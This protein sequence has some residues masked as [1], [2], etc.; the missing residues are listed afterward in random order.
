MRTGLI[1][2]IT[3]T[4]SLS[5]FPNGRT[6]GPA[7]S[8]AGE[9]RAIRIDNKTELPEAGSSEYHGSSAFK[10]YTGRDPDYSLTYRDG[11]FPPDWTAWLEGDF[12][13][14]QD[15]GHDCTSETIDF[16]FNNREN[17]LEIGVPAEQNPGGA[18]FF[19]TGGRFQTGEEREIGRFFLRFNV[20]FNP[21]SVGTWQYYFYGMAPTPSSFYLAG[22]QKGY[23]ELGHPEFGVLASAEA[24]SFVPDQYNLVELLVSA[25]K[26]SLN[27]N[28]A[29]IFEFH[30]TFSELFGESVWKVTVPEEKGL[31]LHIDEISIWRIEL[32]KVSELPRDKR[33][34]FLYDTGEE[35]LSLHLT[36]VPSGE[37]LMGHP[38]VTGRQSKVTLDSFMIGTYPVTYGEWN[39]V[40]GWAEQ[41]GYTFRNKALHGK[42][43]YTTDLDTLKTPATGI[44]WYDAA[45]W[46]NA[47]SEYQGLTPLYYSDSSMQ[48]VYRNSNQ[49]DAEIFCK[50]E[51]DGYRL[52]T[53]AEWEYAA[54]SAGTTDGSFYSG[55][56]DPRITSIFNENRQNSL[57]VDT[58]KPNPLGL[59]DM[60]GN[61]Y[62][63]CWDWFSDA[64]PS[65]VN[66]RG[67]ATGTE[68]I[69]RGASCY[70]PARE[71]SFRE[72]STEPWDEGFECLRVVRCE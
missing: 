16:S 52:P 4:V 19:F 35:K 17:T 46:C 7:V 47:M 50:W 26:V 65:G 11:E 39:E 14:Y 45:A 2:L 23:F 3:M 12:P 44:S 71:D 66:P 43:F 68:R 18:S 29:E 61:A 21:E 34:F 15:W 13:R 24:P 54:R 41:S 8:G 10:D 1:L 31:G 70:S 25:D 6:E 51:S 58:M 69:T 42:I 40:A 53:E 5:V 49:I 33:D 32:S 22:D 27:V 37:F 20:L 38:S 48:R 55:S 36:A 57:A 63:L 60:S 28:E 56:P 9:S 67:P 59:F 72:R 30:Y 62:E 64:L